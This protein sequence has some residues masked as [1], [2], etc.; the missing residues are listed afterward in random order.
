MR[1]SISE[2]AD[3]ACREILNSETLLGIAVY[4]KAAIEIALFSDF[5]L[6]DML[7]S[8]VANSAA[9]PLSDRESVPFG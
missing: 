2:F 5:V 9:V 8:A 4:L 3:G 6:P 1:G 7:Q